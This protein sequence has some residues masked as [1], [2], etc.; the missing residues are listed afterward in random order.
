MAVG[1][2]DL[3]FRDLLDDGLSAVIEEVLTDIEGLV[4]DVVELEHDRVRLPALDARM[5]SEVLDQ[6]EC[7]L[8]TEPTLHHRCLV[9]VALPV[10]EVVLLAIGGATRP[11]RWP[12]AFRR[13]ANSSAG[14]SS[15]QA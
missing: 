11:A 6:S 4:A 14:F 3:A 5:R 9:D 13:Q 15:P 1:A 7:A 2:D 8:V 12:L 10:G